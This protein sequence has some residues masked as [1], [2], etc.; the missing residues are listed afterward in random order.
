MEKG[1]INNNQIVKVLAGI[2]IITGI[3]VM[4]GWFLDIAVLKSILPNWVTMKFTTALSFFLSGI[5]LFLIA[6]HNERYNE[7]AEIM[8]PILALIILMI[9]VTLLASSFLSIHTGIEDLFVKEAEGAV[10]TTTPGRPS[11]GTMVDFILIALAGM[12]FAFEPKNMKK[13]FGKIG[14]AIGIIGGAG[15]LG[16][17]IN[18][19][20][21]YY[22]IEGW[23]TAMALHTAILF[24]LIGIGLFLSGSIPS[25]EKNLEL[26]E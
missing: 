24:T 9:M 15:I 19:P 22:T 10:K 17:I 20:L 14:I 23:S 8:L 26:E 11:M 6:K 7:T 12:L 13:Y 1:K 16:Y 4:L 5:V 21:L 2:V 18:E 25:T 3:I